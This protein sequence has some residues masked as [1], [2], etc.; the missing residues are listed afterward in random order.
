LDKIRREVWNDTRK[1]HKR[2]RPP[3]DIKARA[4]RVT[5]SRRALVRNPERLTDKQALTLAE[6]EKAGS[7]LRKAYLLKELL[8]TLFKELLR[9]LLKLPADETI[10]R[11]DTWLDRV[12]ESGLHEFAR[13]A[14]TIRDLRPELEA[15]LTHRISNGRVESVNAKIRLIQTRASGFHNP[16]AL[17]AL[18]KLTLSGLCPPLPCR[19]AT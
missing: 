4:T 1:H 10:E 13:V 3:T 11:L 6:L 7:P 14:A 16:Y 15:M 18:A 2:G 8:R 19:P 5:H 9:T 17:I 12:D